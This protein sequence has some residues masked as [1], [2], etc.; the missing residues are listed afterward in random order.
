MKLISHRG[1]LYGPDFKNENNPSNI[2]SVISQGYECEIDFWIDNDFL[3]LGH[4]NPQ[5]LI[6]EEFLHT[7]G[8]WIHAKNFSAFNWLLKKKI[9]NNYFW[10]DKDRYT[11]TSNGFAWCYPGSKLTFNSI[12]VLPEIVNKDL[13]NVNFNC[14]GIC[15]DFVANLKIT[16][17]G[18]DLNQRS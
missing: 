1:N 5:Y 4:D 3:F 12:N 15:S 14:Y 13:K 8:L 9:K 7:E 6:K 18:L 17:R 2:L 11:L 10:H 16:S